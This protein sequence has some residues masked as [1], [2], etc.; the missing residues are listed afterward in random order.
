MFAILAGICFLLVL[1]KV[2]VGV[3][4]VVLGLLFIAAHL[5]FG[6]IITIPTIRRD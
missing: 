1:L 2:S 4:L 6:S 5:A 3:D